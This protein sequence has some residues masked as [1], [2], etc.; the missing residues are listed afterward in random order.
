M[1]NKQGIEP[2]VQ[3]FRLGFRAAEL[4]SRVWIARGRE[5]EREREKDTHTYIMYVHSINKKLCTYIYIYYI[6]TLLY[7]IIDILYYD[8]K[9]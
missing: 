1:Q 8:Y 3:S 5:G 2:R 6:Y 9:G 7:Y 4:R